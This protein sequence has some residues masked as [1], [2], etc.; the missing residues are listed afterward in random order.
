MQFIILSL[1][2][3]TGS[4]EYLAAEGW[5]PE[6]AAY[7]QEILAIIVAV[8]IV[9]MG[10][11]AGFQ[12][13]HPTY[14]LV[15]GGI[16][17]VMLCGIVIN[18]VGSGPVFAGLRTYLRA[19]P[20][21]FLPAVFLVRDRQLRTQLLFV[22]L[23]A[24]LQLPIA[25]DQRM[26]TFEESYLSGDRTFGTM[27]TSPA[28]TIFCT[29]VACV[30][31]GFYMRKR[32]RGWVY[33][34]L[35]CIV[36]APT[37]LN[38]TKASVVLVPLGLLTTF[39][40]ASAPQHRLRNGFAATV[41]L[42]L[43]A[44][45]FVPVYDYFM[46]PRWGYGIVE[47]FTM[48]GRLEGYLDK[49]AGMGATK[50]GR[51]DALVVPIEQ[52]ARDP[53]AFAFGY[54]IGN[55]SDSALGREFTGDYYRR[56][57]SFIL[58][59]AT[60]LMLEI[61]MFG[62]G[63]VLVLFLFILRDARIVARQDDGLIGALA[64]GWIGVTVTM[65]ASL[66]YSTIIAHGTFSFLFWYFSGVIAAQRMRMGNQAIERAKE[67]ARSRAPQRWKRAHAAG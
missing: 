3:A 61:G 33:F 58:S 27:L 31:T 64:A 18:G 45:V 23:L 11:R 48:E 46:K 9:I 41:L 53:T 57:E 62:L 21:F 47:F 32:L 16:V 2:V 65:G 15:F 66:F 4:F 37:M 12:N 1:I 50:V 13:V 42:G 52:L 36:L 10:A 5:F 26:T 25:L 38:E 51:V 8:C 28:L 30:L 19:I 17:L 63:C 44:V 43:F 29:C 39:I 20:L 67:A 49:N 34:V 59:S 7:F 35:L 6:T 60:M 22:V 40:V 54:G 24:M 56:Y 55:A 14:W